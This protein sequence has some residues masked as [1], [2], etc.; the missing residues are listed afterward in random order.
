MSP[1]RPRHAR[2]HDGAARAG[3]LASAAVLLASVVL[4]A[5]DPGRGVIGICA[6]TVAVVCGLACR[7][8]LGGGQQ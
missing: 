3:Y 1:E 8:Y 7:I 5:I 6:G 2:R 4:L